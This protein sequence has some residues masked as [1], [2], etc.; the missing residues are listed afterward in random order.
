[1]YERK[2]ISVFFSSSS[3]SF[4]CTVF[5]RICQEFYDAQKK[6]KDVLLSLRRTFILLENRIFI[7]IYAHVHNNIK[8][9]QQCTELAE[10][11]LLLEFRS[12]S[13]VACFVLCE[14]EEFS[15]KICTQ[16]TSVHKGIECWWR[17]WYEVYD[18][19]GETCARA[20]CIYTCYKFW[21]TQCIRS[22]QHGDLDVISGSTTKKIVPEK[23]ETNLAK[24]TKKH[25]TNK[26]NK[27]QR[28]G[29]DIAIA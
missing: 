7:Y 11:L 23:K 27:L 13:V 1:M 18:D 9:C 25:K 14:L 10:M 28:L 19:T 20:M 8:Q 26:K 5:R 12:F 4:P 22:T 2:T 21:C 15:P 29:C 16:P 3:L 17:Q 6:W 24:K